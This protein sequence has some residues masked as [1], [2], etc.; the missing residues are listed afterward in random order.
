MTSYNRKP[1]HRKK[2]RFFSREALVFIFQVVSLS[3]LLGLAVDVVTANVAGVLH[4]SSSPRCGQPFAL[5]NGAGLGNRR[6]LVVR[7]HRQRAVVV[8]ERAAVGTLSGKR[9]L[10]MIVPCL[11]VIWLLMGI[12]AGVYW[13][14]GRIPEKQRRVTF[15]SDRRLMAVVLSH[16]TEY[17][18]GGIVT[19]V[20]MVQIARV[21]E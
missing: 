17:A 18:F 13:I 9:I 1:C 16:S 4:C 12:V 7:P 20:L 21:R 19:I 5:G 10:R 15:E 8:D 11:V 3:C 14:A 6:L 2:R